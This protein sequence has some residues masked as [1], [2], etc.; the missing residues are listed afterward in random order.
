MAGRSIGHACYSKGRVKK[1]AI[2]LSD[3]HIG[4]G[5]RKGQVNL[6]DDFREDERFEQLLHC[7][8]GSEAADDELHLV[9]NGDIFDLLKVSVN[10]KFPDA[11]TERLALMKVEQCLHG[12][13][14]VVK[15]IAR[16]LKHPNNRITFQPG[17]HDMEFLYPGVQR[18][19]CRA[20]TGEDTHPRV[21]FSETPYFELEG[22]IQIHHG[23]QFEAMHAFDFKKLLI[24]RG[25]RE[26]ILN[27]PWGSLFILHVL[28]ELLQERPHLDK[29]M[30][31]WP[32]ILGGMIFDTRFT[33]KLLRKSSFAFAQ[34][35]FN[36]N[37]W[38]KRPFD[39]LSR[40]VRNEIKFFEALDHFAKRILNNP[41]L[42]AVFMGHT[43]C[44]MVRT[45]PRDKVYVNTGTWMPMVSLR[46]AHLGQ[47]LALHYGIVRYDDDG[48]PH[49]S[50]M[51]WHGRRPET[52]EVIA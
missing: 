48:T 51:R 42:N 27:L 21:R 5:H 6:Y 16:V 23:H 31:F 29:I 22:G 37:W 24:T 52:E 15:A 25:H 10:G 30:P 18:M 34:A 3:L 45:Y 4:T 8:T 36:P 47:H 1:L 43:H 32:A 41:R 19:F 12:H 28:N 35:R 14:R 26:P 49:A 44:E 50:L 17:N 39:K 33:L 7:Y 40:F 2:I 46:M 38:Q 13:P 11:I 9:L 20:L